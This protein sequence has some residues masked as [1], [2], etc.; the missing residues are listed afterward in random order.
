MHRC[1]VLTLARSFQPLFQRRYLSLLHIM[2][3]IE[4]LHLAACQRGESFY[5]DAET[6][7]MCL[8]EVAHL[9]RGTCC[10]NRC[11]HCPYGW[12]NVKGA[13]QNPQPAKLESG[14]KLK[15]T[16]LLQEF[17]L[18]STSS[19]TKKNVPY[20]RSGDKGTTRLPSG[21]NRPK[22]D[23]LFEAMGT[24]DELCSVVGVCHAHLMSSHP[25]NALMNDWLVDVMSRL[26][27]IG[28]LIAAEKENED[29]FSEHV[30][31]LEEW[32]DQMT[33]ELP[34]LTSFILPT[35]TITA[36]QF[37]VAR[38]VCRRAER[39]NLGRSYCIYLNRLSDFLFTAARYANHL[40]GV[41]DLRYA[42]PIG[43][44]QRAPTI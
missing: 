32:I 23:H 28:S 8:T 13:P 3:D 20:T 37:H 44:S 18:T 2:H 5:Q 9:Q 40:D 27:D 33:E 11:R 6:G 22:N 1:E 12:Q 19:S 21:E 25:N 38:T 17:G 29:D 26:F 14:D 36:A 31:N 39:L 35:G 30:D 16:K 43:S 34:N 4:D 15:A 24:V 10:G 7:L 41:P 42:K